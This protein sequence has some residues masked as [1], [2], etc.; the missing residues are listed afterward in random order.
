MMEEVS[1]SD[2]GGHIQ[3]SVWFIISRMP[4]KSSLWAK[5][6]AFDY[7]GEGDTGWV[8]L[9]YFAGYTLKEDAVDVKGKLQVIKGALYLCFRA[10]G[11]LR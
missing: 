4:E 3:R 11:L 6:G 2:N 5:E 7:A 1:L 8:G 9:I 10:E